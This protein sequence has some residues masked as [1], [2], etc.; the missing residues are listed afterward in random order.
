MTKVAWIMPKVQ[1]NDIRKVAMYKQI[2]DNTSFE[3]AFRQRQCDTFTVPQ[4]TDTSW[5]LGVRAAPEKPAYIIIGFQTGKSDNQETNPAL[6]DHCNL[7]DMHVVLNS[8]RY[9]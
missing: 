4:T 9:P 1:P 7:K 5:R 3:A 6:F 2:Q 8:V